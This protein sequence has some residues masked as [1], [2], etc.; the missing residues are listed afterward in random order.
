M[1]RKKHEGRKNLRDEMEKPR[2]ARVM[3]QRGGFRGYLSGADE[4][5]ERMA[6]IFEARGYTVTREAPR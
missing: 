3:V 5:V 4:T 2:Y 6:A 1:G